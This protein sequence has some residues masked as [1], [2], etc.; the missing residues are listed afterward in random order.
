MRMK[1][2]F[3]GEN[4]LEGVEADSRF[5]REHGFE[6]IEYNF[7]G[8]FKDLSAETVAK[9]HAIHQRHGV[10]ACMLGIWG[11]NHLHPD[12]AKR[13]EAHAML[14]KAI[15]FARTLG[16]DVLVTG[17]GEFPGETPARTA[18]EFVKVF[19]PFLDKIRAAGL[20][21]AFYALHSGSFFNDIAA[22]ER[23]WEHLPDA[24][25]KF[26]AAN[27]RHHGGDDYLDV[28]RRCGSKIGHVHVKEHLYDRYGKLVAQPPA[29]MGDIEW[30]K[31]LAWLYEHNYNGWLSIEPHGPVWSQGAMREK[32]LLITKKYLSQFLV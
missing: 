27:W 26:D 7:W 4:S 11:W 14:D 8:D 2:G 13:A 6:G 1:L 30:G 15:G 12:A 19:P 21:P 23:V 18:A 5:A 16:A 10:R 22:L 31:V 3:I 32:M 20:K 17:G 9:M 29:G 24:A 25:I 28:V